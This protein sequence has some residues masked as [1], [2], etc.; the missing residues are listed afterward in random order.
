MTTVWRLVWLACPNHPAERR[1]QV[2]MKGVDGKSVP[3]ARTHSSKAMHE[4]AVA[5]LLINVEHW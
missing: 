5:R 4:P 1:G 2:V 3:S